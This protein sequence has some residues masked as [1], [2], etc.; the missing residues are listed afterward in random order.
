MSKPAQVI[1]DYFF[2]FA[3]Q[4]VKVLRKALEDGGRFNLGNSRGYVSTSTSEYDTLQITCGWNG[5]MAY[6]WNRNFLID[7]LELNIRIELRSRTLVGI[8]TRIDGIQWDV[9]EDVTVDQFNDLARR[10]EQSAEIEAD[11]EIEIDQLANDQLQELILTEKM[12]E[13]LG[14]IIKRTIVQTIQSSQ[15]SYAS[16][17]ARRHIYSLFALIVGVI[18]YIL[19]WNENLLWMTMI[20]FYLIPILIAYSYEENRKS[21][22][23]P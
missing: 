9:D 15:R 2:H 6:L 19:G 20:Y 21:R 17:F 16:D 5:V 1:S 14:S 13:D 22:F 4:I 3:N 11:N 7:N 18:V 8:N 10:I 12:K 23:N